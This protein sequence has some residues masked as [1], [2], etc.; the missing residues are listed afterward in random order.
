[1]HG[2]WWRRI[3]LF[4]IV[5]LLLWIKRHFIV[6]HGVWSGVLLRGSQAGKF[7]CDSMSSSAHGGDEIFFLLGVDG[8]TRSSWLIWGSW[9]RNRRLE[10]VI[11]VVI[12][13]VQYDMLLSLVNHILLASSSRRLLWRLRL[14]V[15]NIDRLTRP[16]PLEFILILVHVGRI[17]SR[18]SQRFA[19][20]V[21]WIKIDHFSLLAICLPLLI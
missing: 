12:V 18:R 21:F 2:R 11:H 1:M 15:P 5:I 9:W 6:R 4:R 20:Q 13:I 14:P 10:E 7:L 3:E 8:G 19:R 17:R 16:P